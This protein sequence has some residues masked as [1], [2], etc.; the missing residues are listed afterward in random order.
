MRVIAFT[1]TDDIFAEIA[2]RREEADHNIQPWQDEI[3]PGCYFIR[4]IDFGGPL[5]IFGEVIESP[6][7]EDR[8]LYKEP[9]MKGYRLTRCFSVVCPEGEL[10]DTHV[11]TMHSLLSKEQFEK[12]RAAHWPNTREGLAEVLQIP[13]S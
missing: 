2:Q 5:V 10:G 3:I 8:E 13:C 4:L 7:E 6:Y 11:S 12:A 9:H 1:E